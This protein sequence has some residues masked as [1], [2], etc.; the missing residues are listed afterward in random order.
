MIFFE[1]LGKVVVKVII[2]SL[3]LCLSFLVY[4]YFSFYVLKSDYVNV[5]GYT[6]FEVGSGSMSPTILSNDVIIVKLNENY[7]TNDIVTFY[8]DDSIVTHRIVKIF[9]DRIITKGDANNV[10]DLSIDKDS[11]IGKVV[12]VWKKAGIWKKVF[13]SPRVVILVIITLVLFIVTFSYDSHLYRKFRM[14]K[15]SKK[16]IRDMKKSIRERDKKERKLRK[17]QHNKQ[18]SRVRGER[19]D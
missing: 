12:F 13:M 15:L 1:K 3:F 11:I 8:F 19:H 16:K 17:G 2:A 6:F 4:C 14:R 7:Q 5:F 10:R 18:T 9:D